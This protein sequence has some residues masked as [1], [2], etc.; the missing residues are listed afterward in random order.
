MQLNCLFLHQVAAY[1]RDQSQ[2]H[3]QI[4]VISLKEEFYNRADSLIGIYPEVSVHIIL[5][6]TDSLNGIYPEVSVHIVLCSTD[7][8]IR[9]YPEVSVHIILCS[10]ENTALF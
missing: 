1:I 9:I 6:S 7:S 2:N 4:I 5:C 8:L 3:F 10:T